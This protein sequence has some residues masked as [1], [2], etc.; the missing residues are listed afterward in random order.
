MNDAPPGRSGL[1]EGEC[2]SLDTVRGRCKGLVKNKRTKKEN[3]RTQ[4]AEIGGHCWMA[5]LRHQILDCDA[6]TSLFCVRSLQERE[7]EHW[8]RALRK[9]ADLWPWLTQSACRCSSCKARRFKFSLNPLL[10]EQS[11]VE[12]ARTGANAGLTGT[13]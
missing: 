3:K 11:K 1:G 13:K 5:R 10:L 12:K 2:R 7:A 9:L 4:S 8:A 6:L